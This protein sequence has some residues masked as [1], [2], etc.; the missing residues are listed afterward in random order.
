MEGDGG[1]YGK[2]HDMCEKNCLHKT[3][4]YVRLIPPTHRLHSRGG[5]GSS[6]L[7]GKGELF[8]LRAVSHGSASL[9]RKVSHS[10]KSISEAPSGC[11]WLRG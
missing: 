10:C 9:Q 1:E 5:I 3:R 4:N 6:Q 7:L 11:G 8:P 2:M